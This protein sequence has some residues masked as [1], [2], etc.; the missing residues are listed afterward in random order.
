VSTRRQILKAGI[1]AG[2]AVAIKGPVLLTARTTASIIDATTIPKYVTPLPLLPV[3]PPSMA[4]PGHDEYVVAARQITQQML[5]DGYPASTAYGFGSPAHPRTFHTPGYTIEAR[6]GRRT[7]VTWMNQLMD[8]SRDFLPPL[9][10]VD[11][12]LHW[13]NPPGGVEGRDSMPTFASTPPPYTGPVPLLVHLHGVHSYQESDGYPEA[14]YL[15][16]ARNIPAG[17]ATVGT[18]YDQFKDEALDRWGVRWSPGSATFVYPLDQRAAMLWYHDHSLGM[19]RCNVY[20]G[21]A[22]L[23]MVRG[24]PYDLPPG[25][26]PGPAARLGDRPGTRYYEI[27]MVISDKSFNADGSQYFPNSRADHGDTTG[28]YVPQTDVAPYWNPSVLGTT[29]LVNGRTW[30]ALDVEPRRYRFRFLIASN[31]R[32]Y[33]LKI[34]TDPL[35][36]RPATAALPIWVIGGFLPAPQQSDRLLMITGERYDTIVDFTGVSPGTQ[37]YLI[38]EGFQGVGVADPETV[39]QIMRFNVVPLTSPDTSTP[40]GQLSL[41]PFSVGPSSVTRQL[42]MSHQMSTYLP[43]VVAGMGVGT[44]NADGTPNPIDWSAPVT[45]TPA[46]NATETWEI[47]NFGPTHHA[48]HVHLVEFEVINR[49]PIAGG[50]VTAPFP[51]ETGPKDSVLAVETMITRFRATFD[52]RGRYVWHCH[53]IDHEDKDMM[54]P[55]QVE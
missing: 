15:P 50:P 6:A 2:A 26:L 29:I 3:M 12:T 49:Q 52:R 53:L 34:V 27:P 48:M 22:G 38:N 42:S 19:T 13:A 17:Y 14:W 4:L 23:F 37:L 8:S 35:A 40:P 44:L 43:G 18:F 30:P 5:P 25:V 54:R 31:F 39:G 47:W 9:V 46:Y 33:I 20:P 1:L 32:E 45:E 24:G 21:L 28:P 7:H 55:L 51:W 11:P 10:T 16:A 36:P 41:P